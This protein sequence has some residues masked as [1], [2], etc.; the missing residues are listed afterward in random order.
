M[1][2]EERL[3]QSQAKMNELMDKF[4]AFASDPDA[5]N[6]MFDKFDEK[7]Q[8]MIV[9]GIDKTE[10]AFENLDDKIDESIKV[11]AEKYDKAASDFQAKV[12]SGLESAEG[13]YYAAKE[14]ARMASEEFQAQYNSN[15][16]QLQMQ[17]EAAK[18]KIDEKKASVDKAVQEELINDILDYA[19]DCQY[20]A[21][22]YATEAQAAIRDASKMI[23]EYDAKYGA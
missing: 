16:I 11:N 4:N 20:M 21:Y 3:A 19:D 17:M 8:N 14:N 1:T 23:D 18:A 7:L 10:D 2:F 9:E 13:D 5:V 15:L 6:K 22:A 12:D